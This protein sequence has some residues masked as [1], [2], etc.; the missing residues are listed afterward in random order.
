MDLGGNLFANTRMFVATLPPPAGIALTGLT[1]DAVLRSTAAELTFH[2]AVPPP[3]AL[4]VP[5]SS[6]FA[7]TFTVCE[8]ANTDVMLTDGAD[9]A[10][11]TT[12]IDALLALLPTVIVTLTVDVLPLE[13]AGA[14]NHLHDDVSGPMTGTSTPRI[15]AREPMTRRRCRTST[16]VC[17]SG[18]RVHARGR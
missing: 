14:D 16:A 15:R 3:D 4:T 9:S 2:I 6:R 12:A 7:F 1:N 5:D 17:G 13:L 18:P 8:A 11:T 10:T